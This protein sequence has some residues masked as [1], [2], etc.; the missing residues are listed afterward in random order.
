MALLV[1]HGLLLLAVP[2][3]L[4]T[5]PRMH[6]QLATNHGGTRELAEDLNGQRSIGLDCGFGNEFEGPRL[7]GRSGGVASVDEYVRVE[8]PFR[9]DQARPG[10]STLN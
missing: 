1:W 8:E 6:E 2:A 9:G 10:P 5:L 7:L 4:P 3:T